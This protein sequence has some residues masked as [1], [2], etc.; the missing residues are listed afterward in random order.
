MGDVIVQHDE[1]PNVLDLLPGL[2]VVFVDVRLPDARARKHLHEARD[3]ALNKVNAGGLEWFD[4]A[5]RETHGN[6]VPVPGLE[7][8]AGPELD[9]ARIRQDLALDVAQQ[10]LAGGVIGDVPAAIH[11]V[12]YTHLTLPTSD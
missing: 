4:E 6:H 12:S 1:V 10:G 7:A 3:T 8:L 2:L 11:P 9:D 5:A